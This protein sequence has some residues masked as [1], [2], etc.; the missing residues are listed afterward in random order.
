MGGLESRD[1]VPWMQLVNY[2]SSVPF[3]HAQDER[4]QEGSGLTLNVGPHGICMLMDWAP[5]VN[6]VL[7]LEMPLPV[8]HLGTPTLAEVRWIRSLPFGHSQAYVVGLRFVL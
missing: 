7:R 3:D 4:P 5:P 8:P 1:R 6:E 2:Q